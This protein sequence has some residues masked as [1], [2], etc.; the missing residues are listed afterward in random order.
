VR[1]TN[2][3]L[4]SSP[5]CSSVT[6]TSSTDYNNN[7]SSD[8]CPSL[9]ANLRV[10]RLSRVSGNAANIYLRNHVQFWGVIDAPSGCAQCGAEGPQAEVWGAIITHD[11]NA[12]SQLNLHYDDS[13]G[14]IG[15]GRRRRTGARNR[16]LGTTAA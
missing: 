10:F 5:Q 16:C 12:N 14:K 3:P 2:P 11:F 7:A 9:S 4:L 8:Y 1:V 13:L 6:H 15:T